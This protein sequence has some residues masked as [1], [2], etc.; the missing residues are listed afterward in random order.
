MNTTITTQAAQLPKYSQSQL[1][2]QLK[3][4][5]KNWDLIV[6]GGGIT[7]AGIFRQAAQSG[8]KVL[9]I[10]QQDF[11]WGTSS[12]SSKMVHGGFRY[13]AQGD[14]QL[15][16]EALH[17]REQMLKEVPGLVD[18]QKFLFPLRKGRFPGRFSLTVLLKVYDLLAGVNDCEYINNADL[19]VLLDG[20]DSPNTKGAISY[21]DAITDDSRLVMRVIQE[22]K[23][24]GGIAINYCKALKII[25]DKNS[26]KVDALEINNQEC[27]ESL[28]LHT[29]LIVNAT[30]AWADNLM[31]TRQKKV[32]PLRGSHLVLNEKKFPL[33]TAL[34][35]IHP[36][37]GRPVFMFPWCGRI[38]LGTT[39]LDYP[40]DLD[41]EAVITNVEID[42]L[43]KV[44]NEFFPESN[45]NRSD[46]IATFCGVRPVISSGKGIDPS[47]EKRGHS[48]WKDKGLISVSGGK[49]TIFRVIA[50][51]VM[52]EVR[53][54]L[55][56]S[57]DYK[58]HKQEKNIF[59]PSK[60]AADFSRFD[61]NKD[62]Q[63]LLSG[64]YGDQLQNFLHA[65]EAS[66]YQ[67]ISNYGFSLAD[68][69]WAIEYEQ[70][71]HLDDLLLR[72][73]RLGLLDDC[74][75]LL[76]SLADLM[77]HHNKWAPEQRELELARYQ[78]IKTRY[79]RLPDA[80][81]K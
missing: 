41:I 55:S 14:I 1:W 64:R 25:R 71:L 40:E 20:I 47:K 6:V 5:N 72:R 18:R 29:R 16:R 65:F 17:E 62:Y 21:S 61:F 81:Q 9:L 32:R 19:K 63:K 69:R 43:L 44:L 26:G 73:T 34:T 2:Q 13:I 80:S 53:K 46:I 33:R 68:C 36:D 39:D 78:Q 56:V 23:S 66:E 24:F 42:Y 45:S 74:N 4:E 37:D 8:Y 28:L 77:M 10:E 11:S 58:Q 75:K 3:S 27:G 38:L 30:G 54:Y 57:L 52:H 35:L 31:K 49:L 48:I 7:G 51:E 12:R 60:V 22:G 67:E 59:T 79:Y 76:E 15:T 50:D 70:V